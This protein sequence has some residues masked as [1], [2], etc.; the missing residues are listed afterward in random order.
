MSKVGGVELHRGPRGVIIGVRTSEGACPAEKFLAGL[1]A[2]GQAKFGALFERLT[3]V[4]FL[5]SP[6]LMRDIQ[7]G[8][9]PKVWEIKA[10]VGPGWRLYV[11]QDE[12][13]WCATHGCKKPKDSRVPVEANRARKIYEEWKR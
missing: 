8:R 4:G 1:D 13:R 7:D 6:E 2:R 12:N 3:T 10:H 11:I 9:Q 5:R